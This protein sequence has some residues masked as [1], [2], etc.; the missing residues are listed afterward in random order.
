M[1]SPRAS[2]ATSICPHRHTGR[3]AAPLSSG[4]G[5]APGPACCRGS[6]IAPRLPRPLPGCLSF[7]STSFEGASSLSPNSRARPHA[8]TRLPGPGCGHTCG[9]C[10]DLCGSPGTSPGARAPVSRCLLCSPCRLS[11]RPF[12]GFGCLLQ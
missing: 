10:P 8:A 4:P 2:L 9:P 7:A 5:T 1:P 12:S 6:M 3:A 11:R